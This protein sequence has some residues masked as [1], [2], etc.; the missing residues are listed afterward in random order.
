MKILIKLILTLAV[1]VMILLACAIFLGNQLLP[2]VAESLAPR[3]TGYTLK[4][5]DPYVNLWRGEINLKGMTLEQEN[6]YPKPDK[7]R[8]EQFAVNVEMRSLLSSTKV[9]SDLIVD[10]EEVTMVRRLADAVG[11]DV[12]MG[13]LNKINPANVFEDEEP[14]SSESKTMD[15]SSEEKAGSSIQYLIR[16][17]TLRVNNIKAIAYLPGADIPITLDAPLTIDEHF[18]N[19]SDVKNTIKP[20][21]TDVMKR[22]LSLL[23][24]AITKTFTSNVTNL[25]KGVGEGAK[26]LVDS[27]FGGGSSSDSEAADDEAVQERNEEEESGGLFGIFK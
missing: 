20:I 8:I 3:L 10:V 6:A 1:V 21:V 26:G 13:A 25:T 19:V 7:V 12:I 27:L 15:A 5:E 16:S 18:V 11:L 22:S 4:I 17:F 2:T 23:G 24:K 14:Q 9:L